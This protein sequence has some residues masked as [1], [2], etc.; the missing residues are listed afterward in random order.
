MDLGVVYI[1]LVVLCAIGFGLIFIRMG[2]TPIVGYIIA[3]MILGP[4]GIKFIH[5]Q[6]FIENLADYGIMFLLFAIGLNLSIDKI[7]NIWKQGIGTIFIGGL[8]SAFIFLLIGL[9]FN[10][11]PEFIC[12]ATFCSIPSSTAITVKS[13]N[14][15]KNI[16]DTIQ[17][18]TIGILILQDIISL[19]FIIIIRIIGG[20]TIEKNG[21]LK[22][23]AMVN[24]FLVFYFLITKYKKYWHNFLNYLKDQTDILAITTITLCI[25]GAALASLFG[26][27]TAFGSFIAG[28]VLG[29]SEIKEELKKSTSIIEEILL[30]DFFLSI[31]LFIDLN[32]IFQNFI[33]IMLSV[34]SIAVV[35]TFI[36]ISLLKMFKFKLQDAFISGILLGHLGEFAF[37][38]TS[39]SFKY[40][41]IDISG[42]NF[43]ITITALSLFF[44][45]FWLVIAERCKKITERIAIESLWKMLTLILRKERIIT[46][47]IYSFIK[48]IIISTYIICFNRKEK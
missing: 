46:Q 13:L 33:V 6:K 45:P 17:N 40:N 21:I 37:V 35:K 26:L 9:I 36:N 5:N 7:K 31:G 3:G 27:S 14:K 44:S 16:N 15:I 28:L 38:I 20:N 2:Q 4:S 8:A 25:G 18:S 12:I 23:L 41:L 47:K 29:N 19:F 42:K 22:F 34:L 32:Y 39:E 11:P 10:W 24:A 43:L 48:A 30:M 1:F